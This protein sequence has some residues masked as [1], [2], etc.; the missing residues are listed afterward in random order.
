VDIDKTEYDRHVERME[1]GKD[2][3]E[4]ED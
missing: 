1:N 4:E 2:I 3:N